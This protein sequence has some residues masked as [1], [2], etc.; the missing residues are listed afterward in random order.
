MQGEGCGSIFIFTFT[1]RIKSVSVIKNKQSG[2]RFS[3]EATLLKE[4]ADHAG[5]KHV[6][7]RLLIG[8]WP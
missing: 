1:A 2:A 6:R 8:K 5:P 3:P 4:R 7:I